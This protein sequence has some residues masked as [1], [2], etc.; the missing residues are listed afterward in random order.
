MPVLIALVVIVGLLC[1]A[2]LLLSFGIVR[3]LREHTALLSEQRD[4]GLTVSG[5]NIGE[6]PAEFAHM[7]T[8]G[9]P[10]TGPAGL[11]MVAFLS[12]SCSICPER[13]PGFL[14]YLEVNLL[15][16]DDVMAVIVGSPAEPM[17]Y[18]DSIA[19]VSRVCFESSDVALASAFKVTGYPA[20]Y[21]LDQG[22]AIRSVSH[23]PAL[24]PELASA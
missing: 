5:L 24:L 21:L 22:G 14:S 2:D 12:S 7:S 20:F 1:L 19:T 15:G 6:L 3:R 9:Q 10:V 8:D 13:V 17:A 16:R 4:N 23:D 11:S 18:L